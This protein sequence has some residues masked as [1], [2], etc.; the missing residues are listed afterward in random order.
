MAQATLDDNPDHVVNED[1]DL[2]FEILVGGSMRGKCK[3]K[4]SRGYTY[5][6][7]REKGDKTWWWCTK[8]GKGFR[9][10]AAVSQTGDC[11][12]LGKYPHEHPP[13][14]E[15]FSMEGVD[16]QVKDIVSSMYICSPLDDNDDDL[17]LSNESNNSEI[18]Q[19]PTRSNGQPPHSGSPSKKRKVESEVESDVQ[20]DLIKIEKQR[21][22]VDKERLHV[23]KQRLQ[24]EK[25]RLEKTNKRLEIEKER[26]D[27][28]KKHNSQCTCLNQKI[29]Y[30]EKS[31]ML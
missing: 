13:D 31:E 11:F 25:Q 22:L 1:D 27:E 19:T 4:D 5:T 12:V 6:V 7:K 14:Q 18:Q 2:S 15:R 23:E 29:Q 10:A 24:I 20:Q 16:R 28:T 8:R 17:D 30:L 26:L 21:L 3:L 9:C